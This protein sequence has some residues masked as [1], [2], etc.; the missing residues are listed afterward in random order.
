MDARRPSPS[1]SLISDVNYS[2][3]RGAL[4]EASSAVMSSWRPHRRPHSIAII[5]RMGRKV[6]IS[7]SKKGR[8]QMSTP[9]PISM[10]VGHSAALSIV[11]LDQNGNPMV[12]TPTPDSPPSWTN[13]PNP[14]GDDTLTPASPGDTV[15]TLTANAAG[16]DTVTVSVTVGGAV[17]AATLPVN[18]SPAP[19]VLSSVQINPVVS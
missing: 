19:Q 8:N 5:A 13:A 2:S 12:V 14:T 6:I 16:T 4:L 17:F 15:A 18:I 11:Y 1:F 10:S 9:T 3:A 7:P